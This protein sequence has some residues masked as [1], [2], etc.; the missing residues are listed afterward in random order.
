MLCRLPGL[1]SG[2]DPLAGL[3]LGVLQIEIPLHVEPEFRR[4]AEVAGG[5]VRAGLQAAT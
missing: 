2:G 4:G 5:G 3:D 1:N